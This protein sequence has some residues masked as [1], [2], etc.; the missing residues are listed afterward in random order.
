MKFDNFSAVDSGFANITGAATGTQSGTFST[1]AQSGTYVNI[2][3]FDAIG[4]PTATGADSY[5]FMGLQ[6]FVTPNN[7]NGNMPPYAPNTPQMI[8]KTLGFNLIKRSVRP[9]LVAYLANP[10]L[11]TNTNFQRAL[12]SANNQ[13]RP[14]LMR[15]ATQIGG[16]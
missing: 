6:A 15:V 11:T 1:S 16:L 3:S 4:I 8:G 10:N 14:Y 9:A 5:Y 2:G 12:S 7:S 13:L